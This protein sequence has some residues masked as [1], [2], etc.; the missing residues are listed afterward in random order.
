MAKVNCNLIIYE[1]LL[2]T[3]NIKVT[4][5]LEGSFMEDKHEYVKFMGYV[6]LKTKIL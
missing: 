4:K 6:A 5:N 1:R 3:K 2:K